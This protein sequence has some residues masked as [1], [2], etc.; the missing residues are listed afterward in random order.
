MSETSAEFHGEVE[1]KFGANIKIHNHW[2]RHTQKLS[3]EVF[4]TAV[5]GLSNS[6]ISESGAERAKQHGLT[7]TP[8]KDGMKGYV[9]ESNR[10]NQTLDAV[11]EGYLQDP[12]KD[13]SDNKL[14]ATIRSMRGKEE[15][16]AYGPSDFINLY[17]DKWTENKKRILETRGLKLEDFGSLSPDE[18]EEIAED[19]EEPVI[20]EWL[21]DPNGEMAQLHPPRHA[22]AKFASLFNRRH[23]RLASYLK[24]NSEIDIAHGTHKTVTEPFLASGVLI[25]NSDNERITKIDQLG[26]SLRILDNWESETTTDMNGN[27]STKVLIRGEEYHLDPK[28][29]EELSIEGVEQ[30]KK[31]GFVKQGETQKKLRNE[32]NK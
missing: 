7:M 9:S 11:I 23:D 30:L 27:P 10:T 28:V 16:N 8:A 2:I 3:G 15:L 26:G 14:E 6:A 19:A 31:S 21:D 12:D 22:A 13:L 24:T 1:K 5:T 18:Q 20:R 17:N 29:L 32:A 25:R 4:N